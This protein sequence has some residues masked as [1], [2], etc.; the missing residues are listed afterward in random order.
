MPPEVIVKTPE[1]RL[2]GAPFDN[3]ITQSSMAQYARIRIM[4]PRWIRLEPNKVTSILYS[5]AIWSNPSLRVKLLKC[6]QDNTKF[7]VVESELKAD[8][9]ISF[10][11]HNAQIVNLDRL[12]SSS[13]LPIYHGALASRHH[14]YSIGGV[15][16]ARRV[17][18]CVNSSV[19]FR[20]SSGTVGNET[21]D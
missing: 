16:L 4:N 8:V 6:V 17:G 14:T 21:C 3:L 20:N 11:K 15:T 19:F 7:P 18:L 10:H 2:I 5:S 1:S 12:V 9:I 13:D